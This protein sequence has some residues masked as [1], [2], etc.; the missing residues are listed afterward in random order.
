MDS[1]KVC[2]LF[3]PLSPLTEASTIMP[4]SLLCLIKSPCIKKMSTLNTES[5]FHYSFVFYAIIFFVVVVVVFCFV[6][7]F[8]DRVS[9]YSPGCPGTHF[10]D[11]AGLELRNLPAS[12][13]L[14]LGLKA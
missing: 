14:V 8:R 2:S 1:L 7:V 6:F 9:L 13:S 12:A 5:I 11:Q 4:N 3:L 10:V